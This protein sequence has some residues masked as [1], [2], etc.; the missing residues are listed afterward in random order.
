MTERFA[1]RLRIIR[2]AVSVLFGLLYTA[3]FLELFVSI[4]F[5]VIT[6][7]GLQIFP[8]IL[9][10]IS[11]SF[12]ALIIPLILLALTAVFGR[13]YC[14]FLCPLGGIQDLF[15]FGQRKIGRSRR[16][17]HQRSFAVIHYGILV[18][19]LAGLALGNMMVFTLMEPFS[20]FGRI[21]TDLVRQGLDAVING[22]SFLFQSVGIYSFPRVS[23]LPAGSE[24]IAVAFV[25]LAGILVLTF[26]L[27]RKYC[28]TL[29]PTGAL[30]R[31]ISRLSFFRIRFNP[32]KCVSCGLCESACRAGCIDGNTKT[33]DHARCVL[34]FDCLSVCKF[35]AIGYS[36]GLK[37]S[38]RKTDVH[39]EGRRNF[40][41]FMTAG[42][43]SLPFMQNVLH[44]VSSGKLSKGMKVP[45]LPPGSKSLKEYLEKC[46]ACHECVSSCPN[47]IIRP[48]LFDFGLSGLFQPVLDYRLYYCGYECNT[49]T[50]VCPTG[51]IRPLEL[52][53]KKLT[54]IGLSKLIV[55]KCIV[56]DKKLECGACAEHCP[57]KAVHLIRWNG[58]G[59]PVT[60]DELCIGC[61]ACEYVCPVFPKAIS[62]EGL[63]VH[64]KAKPRN[65]RKIKRKA[66]TTEFPF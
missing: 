11:I 3:L 35:S 4:P 12:L 34:C 43:L 6:L 32:D 2:A 20:V 54:R 30:L 19:A 10:T 65:D 16:F 44:A 64:E 5:I 31:L 40:L 60:N 17:R 26:F 29:C 23:P 21:I 62:V 14:S 18:F 39:N 25:F 27:G 46:T 49:C 47:R 42:I 15:L 9:R 56:Y 24:M 57:N 61:G 1:R 22:L 63:T 53:E 38:T 13:F 37:T 55:E 66:A 8:S 50:Q 33:V 28:N 36:A 58:L 7:N 48:A 45:I 51:A 41:S 59:A 52:K